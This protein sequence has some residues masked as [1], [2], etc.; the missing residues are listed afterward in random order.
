MVNV[1]FVPKQTGHWAGFC[2]LRPVSC[3]LFTMKIYVIIPAFNEQDAIHKVIG[4]IPSGLV[5]ETVVVS[6]G[7]T[8]ATEERAP[9][10]RGHCAAGTTKGLWRSLPEG[11]GLPGGQ[12]SR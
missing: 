2:Y 7:S 5:T 10:C 12:A 3:L 4:D 1:L 6:N 8:D 11:H 9:P